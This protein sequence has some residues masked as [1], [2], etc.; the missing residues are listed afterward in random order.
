MT[1]MLHHH[2]S[3]EKGQTI[4]LLATPAVEYVLIEWKGDLTGN[5]NPLSLT[6]NSDKRV[7]GKF[8]K[9]NIH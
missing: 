5:V 6:M 7:S 2:Q 3:Y 1:E 8:K 9:V 4:Q